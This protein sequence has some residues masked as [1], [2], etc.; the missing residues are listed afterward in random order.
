VKKI[1]KFLAILLF[2][3][4]GKNTV[5]IYTDGGSPVKGYT[6]TKNTEILCDGEHIMM[7]SVKHGFITIYVKDTLVVQLNK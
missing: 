1:I 6:S 7:E 5:T 3:V 2:I 4:I